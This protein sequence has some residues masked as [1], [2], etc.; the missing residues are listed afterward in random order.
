MGQS[1]LP[2]LYDVT[3]LAEQTASRAVGGAM[4]TEKHNKYRRRPHDERFR[5]MLFRFANACTSK[6]AVPATTG[7]SGTAA[8]LPP[9]LLVLSVSAAKLVKQ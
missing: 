7:V 3:S 2:S 6:I 8:Y 1:F 5:M 9:L 4:Q